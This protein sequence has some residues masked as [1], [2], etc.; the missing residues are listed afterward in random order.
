MLRIDHSPTLGILLGMSLMPSAPPRKRILIAAVLV[1]SLLLIATIVIA[2]RLLPREAATTQQ[3]VS[4][5]QS[6]SSIVATVPNLGSR[7][8]AAFRLERAGRL[9]SALVICEQ[10]LADCRSRLGDRATETLDVT[11]QYAWMLMKSGALEKAE[12]FARNAEHLASESTSVDVKSM[13]ERRSTLAGI[14]IAQGRLDDAA[15]LYANRR[16]PA[17][18]GITQTF[19]GSFKADD[20]KAHLLV[21]WEAWCP[22]CAKAMPELEEISKKYAG[23]GLAVEG[24]TQETQNATDDDVRRFIREKGIHFPIVKE[25]GKS[26]SYFGCT[27]VPAIRIIK[28][29]RLVWEGYAPSADRVATR[30][31][32][33]LIGAP[34]KRKP[35][36]S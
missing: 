4:R 2:V 28:A 3:S 8:A 11:N 1:G 19:Q 10:L 36:I 33:G 13:R 32:D 25:N 27:A 5:S 18:W 12:E 9:D 20:G 24:L 26:A 14:L 16:V 6:D 22:H 21:F 15:A 30:M 31:L 34:G 17:Q 29:G 23:R 7:K 35:S